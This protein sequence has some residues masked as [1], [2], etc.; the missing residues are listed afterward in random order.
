MPSG[1]ADKGYLADGIALVALHLYRC[2]WLLFSHPS[3]TW[4]SP[5]E[6]RI[7]SLLDLVSTYLGIYYQI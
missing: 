5:P 4:S 2:L 1:A 6:G 3:P 7:A